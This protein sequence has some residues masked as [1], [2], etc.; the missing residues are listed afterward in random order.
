MNVCTNVCLALAST[1]TIG[2]VALGR[3][4]D[5]PWLRHL[6]ELHCWCERRRELSVFS[7]RLLSEQIFGSCHHVLETSGTHHITLRSLCEDLGGWGMG[8]VGLALNMFSELY[9]PANAEENWPACAG[10]G[11]DAVSL[12][13][14]LVYS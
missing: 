8:G 14:K 3:H 4:P 6:L 11:S 13:F 10:A 2:F 1:I 7:I 12:F 9:Q 5:Q